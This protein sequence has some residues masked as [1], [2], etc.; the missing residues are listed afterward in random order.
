VAAVDE[1]GKLHAR[2]PAVLEEGL[3]GGADGAPRRE[4]VVDEDARHPLERE[5][6]LRRAHDRLRVSRRLA[7][8]HDDVVAMERDVDRAERDFGA[9]EIG[10]VTPN[11]LCE[12]NAPG[13]D[14]DK[15]RA[16]EVAVAFD[17][18]VGD[19]R[20]RPVQRL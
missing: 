17:D 20:D 1:A 4:D 10:N 13:V 9:A 2:R 8:P 7:V 5:V 14:A 18:L 12:R 11:A 19:A 15:S 16:L 6:E 3:D